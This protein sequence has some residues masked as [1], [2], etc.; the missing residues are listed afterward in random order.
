[1]PH[2]SSLVQVRMPYQFCFWS[3]VLSHINSSQKSRVRGTSEHIIG[4]ALP[5]SLHD[6]VPT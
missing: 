3:L 4:E 1:M 2:D 5:L 6:D